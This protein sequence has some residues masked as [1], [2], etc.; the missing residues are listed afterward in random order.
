MSI[1][2][3]IYWLVGFDVIFMNKTVKQIGK[4]KVKCKNFLK[5]WARWIQ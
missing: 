3:R 2:Q 5:L 4:Y 1:I